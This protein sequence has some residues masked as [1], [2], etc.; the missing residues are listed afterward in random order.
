MPAACIITKIPYGGDL[1]VT[2]N[3]VRDLLRA[4]VIRAT[5]TIGLYEMVEGK[6]SDL[7]RVLRNR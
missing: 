5:T 7:W 6:D 3:T 2:V 4:G 1:S